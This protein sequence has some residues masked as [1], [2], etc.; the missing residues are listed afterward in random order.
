MSLKK[1]QQQT[2]A[3]RMLAFESYQTGMRVRTNNSCRFVMLYCIFWQYLKNFMRNG[4]PANA[5][6][7]ATAMDY[8]EI[9]LNQFKENN[10]NFLSA[11]DYN[12]LLLDLQEASLNPPC[13]LKEKIKRSFLVELP[14]I[15]LEDQTTAEDAKVIEEDIV[16]NDIY[17]DDLPP[18]ITLD[19]IQL[20][21]Q[22]YIM[23]D[24]YYEQVAG[25]VKASC[26]DAWFQML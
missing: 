21:E 7:A 12:K 15:L 24:G 5:D 20:S 22:T 3:T 16:N 1:Y 11:A 14:Q 9:A 10:P 6:N 8:V 26:S 18:S 13:R 17:S 4:L 23:V 25:V 19:Q 2:A